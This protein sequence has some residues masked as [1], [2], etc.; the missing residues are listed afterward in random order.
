MDRCRT[1][2]IQRRSGEISD[3]VIV[4]SRE[5][6]SH[7]HSEFS[8]RKRPAVIDFVCPHCNQNL[9]IPEQYLGQSGKCNKCGGSITINVAPPPLAKISA[10]EDEAGTE[11]SEL[12]PLSSFFT[13]IAGVTFENPDGS[14]RQAIIKNVKEGESLQLIREPDNP[15][16]KTGNTTRVCRMNGEQ[17]GY[18]SSDISETIAPRLD[19]GSKCDVVVKNV[20][21]GGGGILK[22][23]TLGVNIEITR[24]TLP[25]KKKKKRASTIE[26]PKIPYLPEREGAPDIIAWLYRELEKTEQFV[27]E[28]GV[29][30][31]FASLWQV[32]ESSWGGSMPDWQRAEDID[33]LSLCIQASLQQIEMSKKVK[34]S[35]KRKYPGEDLPFHAG[36]TRLHIIREKQGLYEKAL[37]ICMEGDKQGWG[38]DWERY[39]K[40]LT[41]KIAENAGGQ[42]M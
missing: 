38:G 40:R 1:R 10:K 22:A 30:G 32:I 18:L 11:I 20:T 25:K 12:K 28:K 6:S 13:K 37:V 8:I 42:G 14:N 5:S 2:L 41:R 4:D 26:I 29:L 23:P 17:L 3:Q 21:S 27:K 24:Y 7:R 36:F 35:F 19:K 9:S 16:S 33:T 34:S 15:F 31:K 39:I